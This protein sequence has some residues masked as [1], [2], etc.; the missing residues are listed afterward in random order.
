[1]ERERNDAIIPNLGEPVGLCQALE[2][3]SQTNMRLGRT[4]QCSATVEKAPVH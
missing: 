1:M 4:F 3:Q 2:Q